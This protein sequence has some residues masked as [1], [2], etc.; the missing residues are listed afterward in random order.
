MNAVQTVLD[1]PMLWCIVGGKVHSNLDL[2]ERLVKK[3][4]EEDGSL[5]RAL[6]I[7]GDKADKLGERYKDWLIKNWDKF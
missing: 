1:D 2:W 5:D 6:A 7:L 4:K 3:F